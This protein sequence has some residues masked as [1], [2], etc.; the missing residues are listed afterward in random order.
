MENDNDISVKALLLSSKAMNFIFS[1]VIIASLPLIYFL[2][3]E[4][5]GIKY[6][7][8]HTMYISII[9][10]GI[11]WGFKGGAFIGVIGGLLLGP[12]MP[13]DTITGEPQELI[14]WVYRLK[15][16]RAHV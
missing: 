8:S 9:F 12:L 3:Y 6:V 13:I 15:I 4:T 5:G 7:F 10:A 11:F 16:G 2:V 14:N 1:V